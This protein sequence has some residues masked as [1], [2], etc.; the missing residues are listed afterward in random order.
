MLK[1]ILPLSN[2]ETWFSNNPPHEVRMRI[3]LSDIPT[4]VQAAYVCRDDFSVTFYEDSRARLYKELTCLCSIVRTN[5]TNSK[6]DHAP[7]WNVYE[8][9]VAEQKTKSSKSV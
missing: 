5:N 8:R 1:M 6:L 3:D 7:F 4:Y 9:I 2:A